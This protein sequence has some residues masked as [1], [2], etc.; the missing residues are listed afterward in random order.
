MK[1]QIIEAIEPEY[2]D[3][4]RNVNTDMIN[5]SIPEMFKF[6]QETY[7][8]ITEEELV[9]K[10]DNLRQYAY[11]LHI[12]VDKVVTKITLFIISVQLWKMTWQI[13][14]CYKLLI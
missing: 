7:G 6:L 3:A 13:S 10:E 11:D 9:E 14:D 12:P 4:L 2:L 8:W 5:E 1:N